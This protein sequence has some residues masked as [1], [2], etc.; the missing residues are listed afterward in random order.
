MPED[1]VFDST[2][3]GTLRPN[4]DALQTSGTTFKPMKL[5]YWGWEITLPEHVSPDD[6]I[7]LFSMYYTPEFIQQIV[8]R[9]N[10]YLRKPKDDSRP[11]ARA[12]GWYPTCSTEIYLYFAI[13][14]YITLHIENEISDY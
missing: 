8:E 1:T 7:T 11:Y 9:T 4:E 14:I 6:P 10:Q 12:N 13:R 5:P 2:D 3:R